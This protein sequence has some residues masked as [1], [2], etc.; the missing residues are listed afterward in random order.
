MRRGSN[1]QS[2]IWTMIGIICGLIW[3][4]Q[5]EYS[6]FLLI[7]LT[8]YLLYRFAVLVGPDEPKSTSQYFTDS[9]L[10]SIEPKLETIKEMDNPIYSKS[11]ITFSNLNDVD[12]FLN[13]QGYIYGSVLIINNYDIDKERIDAILKKNSPIIF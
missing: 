9:N 1:P 7:A 4:I 11:T 3:L 10:K 13:Y 12:N 8:I 5:S 6:Y 2:F